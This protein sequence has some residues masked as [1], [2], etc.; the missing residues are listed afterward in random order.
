MFCKGGID[1]KRHH[2]V[3]RIAAEESVVLNSANSAPYM[4]LV[5]VESEEDAIETDELHRD[6]LRPPVYTLEKS[7]SRSFSSVSPQEFHQQRVIARRKSIVQNKSPFVAETELAAVDE[8]AEKLKTAAV[9][10]AQL[11]TQQKNLATSSSTII[12]GAH[13]ERSATAKGS[14][15]STLA[16]GKLAAHYE[17][18]RARVVKEMMSFEQERQ[19]AQAITLQKSQSEEYLGSPIDEN[20]N[21]VIDEMLDDEQEKSLLQAAAEDP[22]AAVFREFFASKVKRVRNGSKYGESPRW[23]LYSVI[24]KPGADLRQEHLALQLIREIHTIWKKENCPVWIYRYLIF[25]NPN[26]SATKF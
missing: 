7:V 10:L 1:G 16:S 6:T 15:K 26:D 17:A 22:S 18:I 23:K 3:L 12:G 9:M 19:K 25:T 2:K 24:V 11:Y 20:P 13:K 8:F 5:E 14:P 21:A 4:I